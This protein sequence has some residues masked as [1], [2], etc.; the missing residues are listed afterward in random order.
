M[1]I[2]MYFLTLLRFLSLQHKL[3]HAAHMVKMQVDACSNSELCQD[4]LSTSDVQ[5]HTFIL[6]NVYGDLQLINKENYVFKTQEFYF[7]TSPHP[8]AYA[9]CLFTNSAMD[10]RIT[11]SFEHA[12]S[13][14]RFQC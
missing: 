2:Y 3:H 9:M 1:Y 8:M 12:N 4:H 10:L 5:Y 13:M 7:D 11:I 14:I 6:A